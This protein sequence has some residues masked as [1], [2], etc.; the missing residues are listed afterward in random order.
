MIQDARCK[1]QDARS[2]ARPGGLCGAAVSAAIAP[3]QNRRTI[4]ENPHPP[5]NRKISSEW[6]GS[7]FFVLP[8]SIGIQAGGLRS[9]EAPGDDLRT[10]SRRF[11][12]RASRGCP[13]PAWCGFR[14]H[15]RVYVLDRTRWYPARPPIAP[16]R[17]NPAPGSF[18]STTV[19]ATVTGSGWG[20][21]SGTGP[22][23]LPQLPHLPH[24]PH[25]LHL[26]HRSVGWGV[27]T[28]T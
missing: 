8:S 18:L 11:S 27:R 10:S 13:V 26:L 7:S 17:G 6:A 19:T 24:L 9:N 14:A 25:P 22:P 12:R 3:D 2:P 23:H 5:R 28:E 20:S 21:G 15:G 1:M 4:I 16:P